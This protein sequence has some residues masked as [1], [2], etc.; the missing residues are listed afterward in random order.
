MDILSSRGEALAALA[1]WAARRAELEAERPLLMA[2]A[3]NA[4]ARTIAELA[5]TAVVSRDTVYSDLGQQGIDYRN[6]DADPRLTR[7]VR[8]VAQLA[9]QFQPGHP[10]TFDWEK[11][12]EFGPALAEAASLLVS[13]Q[14]PELVVAAEKILAAAPDGN[15]DYQ[16]LAPFLDEL[17]AALEAYRTPMPAAPFTRLRRGRPAGRLDPNPPRHPQ[18]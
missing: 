8:A 9:Q 18:S 17:R 3:W 7:L 12:A 10:F 1:D 6:K 13:F 15:G 5:R 11:A 14:S 16:L 2:A 4:G